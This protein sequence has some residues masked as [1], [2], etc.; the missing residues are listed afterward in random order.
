[1]KRNLG[2]YK[3]FGRLLYTSAHTLAS[4]VHDLSCAKN[5][6]EAV[7]VCFRLAF[8]GISWKFSSLKFF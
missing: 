7:V 4:S 5:N 3:Y 1:M 8:H 2:L 6:R